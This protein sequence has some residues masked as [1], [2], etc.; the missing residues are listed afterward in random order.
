MFRSW[1]LCTRHLIRLISYNLHDNPRRA[2][3]RGKPRR[4]AS[5]RRRWEL[6][7]QT[8]GRCC[9]EQPLHCLSPG[10]HRLGA[11]ASWAAG[12]F[13]WQKRSFPLLYV[14]AAVC[15]HGSQPGPGLPGASQRVPRA[16]SPSTM[17]RGPLLTTYDAGLDPVT[18]PIL[19]AGG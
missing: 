17:A 1:S 5:T 10:R 4:R 8:A 14:C 13:L 6:D 15:A 18:S 7:W 9:S 19:L 12:H 3:E 16:K 11:G 2:G